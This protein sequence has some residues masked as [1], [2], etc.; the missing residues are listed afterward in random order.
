MESLL[1]SKKSTTIPLIWLLF[2]IIITPIPLSNYVLCIGADGHIKFEVGAN[3]QCTDAHPFDSVREEATLTETTSVADHCGSCVDLAIFFPLDTQPHV[4]PAKNVLAH[5]ANSVV[6]LTAVQPFVHTI[7]ICTPPFA[8]P[9]L[10]NPTLISL[11]S[12][13]LLI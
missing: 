1:M 3:G 10:I 9:S 4:V 13:T 8:S 5:H 6:V 7:P 12:T 11:R 2:Y